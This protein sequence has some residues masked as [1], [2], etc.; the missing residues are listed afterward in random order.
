[1]ADQKQESDQQETRKVVMA[2][3]DLSD[4]TNQ[5]MTHDLQNAVGATTVRVPIDRP[6]IDQGELP[7]RSGHLLDFTGNRLLI[8]IITSMFAAIG[9]IVAV[10]TGKWW[11]LPL[12]FFLLVGLALLIITTVLKMTGIREHP[13]P[14]TAAAMQADGVESPD[15]FFSA[16]VEEF[17]EVRDPDI[18]G[19][20]ETTAQDDVAASAAEQTSAMT[21]TSQPSKA[22][23]P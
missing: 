16:A 6:H 1:M 17:T 8:I 2:D 14:T 3:P 15:E 4:N 11:I 12:A 9:A 7:V 18:A 20:R 21:P 23:G 10:S 5:L 13:A 22:V 19:S